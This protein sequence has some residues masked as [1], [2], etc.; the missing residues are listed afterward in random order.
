VA[1]NSSS[2]P[3]AN[4][5]D[6]ESSCYVL[7]GTASSKTGELIQA[8][9]IS[10]LSI[11]LVIN[12]QL[13]HNQHDSVYA[14]FGNQ[15]K[16]YRAPNVDGM[17]PAD[18]VFQA[19]LIATVNIDPND[20][21]T[22]Y[23]DSTGSG[24]YWYKYTYYNPTTDNETDI[25][26]ATAVRGN[27]TADYCSLDEIRREAGFKYAPYVT[28]DQIDEK[29]QAAQDE[30]N[31]ALD[32]FYDTPLK[33]PINSKL[34]QICI[35]L[36]AGY[37]LEAQFSAFSG[38]KT[39]GQDKI[40]WAEAE[41]DKLIMKERVLVGKDGKPQDLPGATG[42]ADSWPNSSTA[43]TPTSQ[44]GAPRL[45]RMGDIQ[46]QPMTVDESGN[47]SGNLYYGRRW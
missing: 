4:T 19:N 40:D 28:D 25:A 42:G 10:G 46:G 9:T 37:L 6:F 5:N 20:N 47:P 8:G 45:F 33:P 14:L 3:V 16:V 12:T 1:A 41:L 23:T 36:A 21:E 15:L 38:P 24:N 44:G 7:I 39:N 29:R 17:Q 22:L 35:V 27:F 26:S 31:G 18:S 30:I 13:A 32:E 34:K 43:T 2:L 11:P